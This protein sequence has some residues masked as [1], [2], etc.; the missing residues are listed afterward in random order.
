AALGGEPAEAVRFNDKEELIVSVS[1][2]IQ[3][4]QSVLGVVT[5]EVGDIQEIVHAAR[6]AILPVFIIAFLATMASSFA[7][8]AF[9]AQP[10]KQLAKAADRVRAGVGR[11]DRIRIPDFTRRKDEIGDLS[12]SLQA[13]TEALFDRLEAI[14]QFA[15]DVA[16]EIKNPLTSIRSAIETLS[17][18]KDDEARAKLM[19]VI[20]DDV[21]RMD[22]LIT[23]IS[24]ASRL[25][26]ELAR[27]RFEILDVGDLLAGIVQS[28]AA[29][30]EGDDGAP[31]PGAPRMAF[32]GADAGAPPLMVRG[33]PE[34]L[35]QVF[36]NLIDNALSFN[37]PGEA[38]RVHA[39]L[40]AG[41]RTVRIE[42]ED[43]GPGVPPENLEAIFKRFYSDRPPTATARSNSGLGLAI[44]K[45]IVEAHRGRIWA[46]NVLEDP[47]DPDGA[48]RGARL[49]VEL[50]A[51]QGRAAD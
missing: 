46:E 42:V 14:E 19:A 26:A 51:R 9:I 28:Y 3:R 33:A 25:D 13:M 10:I 8:A 22:R 27:Q 12:V 41:G 48:R 11:Q 30:F 4:V 18:A 31:A 21:T 16:H 20:Q 5:L 32:E 38:V 23:D 2:P 44:S 6:L 17:I 1:T 34:N 50:P 29:A 47:S 35:A 36:R 37:V 45:Q 49:C 7:L 24:N 39:E 40:N 15:A 43:R